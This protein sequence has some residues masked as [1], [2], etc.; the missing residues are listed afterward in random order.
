M[1]SH[2]KGEPRYFIATASGTPQMQ[3]VWFLLSQSGLIP[4]TL[5]KITPPRFLRPSQKAVSEINLSMDSF[6]RITLPP[7]ETLE[8]AA[9]NRNPGTFI[10]EGKFREALYNLTKPLTKRELSGVMREVLGG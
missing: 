8:I 1:A 5:L 2:K 6:P 9:T 7:P 10:A 4:A 3:T